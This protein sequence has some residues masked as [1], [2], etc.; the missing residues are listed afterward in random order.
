M[1]C[2]PLQ[3]APPKSTSDAATTLTPAMV[4]EDT[5]WSSAQAR[6]QAICLKDRNWLLPKGYLS[7][8]RR[9]RGSSK[10]L[11]KGGRQKD[12]TRSQSK[13]G[14]VWLGTQLPSLQGTKGRS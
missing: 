4:R 8:R 9:K 3:Q 7:H 5:P 6:C 1:T 13:R 2:L 10:T 12:R 14:K 11:P